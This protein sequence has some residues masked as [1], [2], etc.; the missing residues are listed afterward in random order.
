M[1]TY[2]GGSQSLNHHTRITSLEDPNSLKTWTK[3]LTSKGDSGFSGLMS[4]ATMTGVKSNNGNANSNI[5]VG[6]EGG[7]YLKNMI[8]NSICKLAILTTV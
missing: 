2:S 3:K 8:I 1:K 4:T 6:D 7:K 5:N